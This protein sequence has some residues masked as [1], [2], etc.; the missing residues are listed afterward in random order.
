[1][2]LYSYGSS[3][4]SQAAQGQSSQK[5]VASWHDLWHG[6][7]AAWPTVY[8]TAWMAYTVVYALQHG[9]TVHRRRIFETRFGIAD[10]MSIARV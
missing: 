3:R 4:R 6:V 2:A 5:R 9:L 7:C 1:M 8:A 10:G